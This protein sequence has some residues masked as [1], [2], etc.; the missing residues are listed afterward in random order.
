MLARHAI[1]AACKAAGTA[2]TT[3]PI[4]AVRVHVPSGEAF[5][6]TF[7]EKRGFTVSETTAESVLME[8]TL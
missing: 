2:A 3:S 4:T 5:P 8:M 1:S 6:R 7:F